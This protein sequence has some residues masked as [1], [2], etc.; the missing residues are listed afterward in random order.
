VQ[1][2]ANRATC[3]KPSGSL[4]HCEFVIYPQEVPVKNANDYMEDHMTV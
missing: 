2:S 1:C 4:S 3:S